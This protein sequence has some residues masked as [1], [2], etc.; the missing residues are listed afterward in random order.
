MPCSLFA[1]INFADQ[2]HAGQVRDDGS[3]YILHPISVLQILWSAS[4]DLPLE[5]SIAAVLHDVL[6]DTPTTREDIVFLAG[7]GVAHAVS[8]LT[9]P[10]KIPG[11]YVDR[12][13]AEAT[14]LRRL[15]TSSAEC[16]YAPLVKLADR[17]HNVETAASIGEERR[18]ALAEETC[19][20]YV[21]FFRSGAAE[22]EPYASAHTALLVRLARSC[23]ILR[24]GVCCRREAEMHAMHC[25]KMPILVS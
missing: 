22:I 24:D 11:A 17:I 2:A 10:R 25:A 6:E 3:P 7:E 8:L 16:P 5:A 23:L 1:A 14:Y 4:I 13:E 9:R 19:D 18:L 15:Q 21:P 20:L 12:R